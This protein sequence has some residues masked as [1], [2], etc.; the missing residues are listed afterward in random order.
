MYHFHFKL[1]NNLKSKYSSLVILL[2]LPHLNVPSANKMDGL[3]VPLLPLGSIVG[4]D[5]ANSHGV[6]HY[7]RHQ[8][9]QTGNDGWQP[10]VWLASVLPPGTDDISLRL[11][12]PSDLR[13]KCYSSSLKIYE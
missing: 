11:Q 3:G 2:F 10:G 7:I 6:T 5:L 8:P 4:D 12:W 13:K 9:L 1:R